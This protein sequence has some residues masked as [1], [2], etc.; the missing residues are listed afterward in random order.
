MAISKKQ[1]LRTRLKAIR[2]TLH[3]AT[4]NEKEG[5]AGLSLTENFNTILTEIKDFV[6]ETLVQIISGVVEAQ[7]SESVK[8]TTA[9]IAPAGQGVQD[10]EL[11]NRLVEFDVAVTTESGSE[12]KGGIGVFVGPMGLGSKGRSD[13][14]KALINRIRFSVP[15]YLPAQR[16][17]RQ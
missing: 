10:E 7:I 15:I 3:G 13:S 9:A 17:R 16:L 4:A 11:L 6:R 12:T 8:Q 1:L 14:S 5:L 2:S